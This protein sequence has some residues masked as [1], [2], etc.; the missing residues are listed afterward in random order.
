MRQQELE[1]TNDKGNE[2]LKD[3]YP[4]QNCICES[5]I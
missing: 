2:V 5:Q 3:I 1:K 4:R